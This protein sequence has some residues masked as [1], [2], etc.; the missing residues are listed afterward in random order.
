MRVSTHL[1]GSLQTKPQSTVSQDSTISILPVSLLHR[2]TRLFFAWIVIILLLVPIIVINV[3]SSTALR[4]VII[5]IATS[6][7]VTAITGIS[8]A[9]SHEIL[10]SGA[11]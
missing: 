6:I 5:V 10:V 11:T 1:Q 2:L 8:N 9:K 3:I 4:L 7:L